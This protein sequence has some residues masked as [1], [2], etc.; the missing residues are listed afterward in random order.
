MRRGT[1]WLAAM[2]ILTFG[3]AACFGDVNS[4]TDTD[5]PFV[6]IIF[7]R[8]DSTVAGLVT[9]SATVQDAF[10]VDKVTFTIDGN[11][12]FEDRLPPFQANWNTTSV[13]NGA[14]SIRVEATDPS[15]NKGFQN[16]G[17][18]VDNRRN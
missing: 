4:Q 2:A 1:G 5:S 11:L 15:G 14:H 9:I 18:L 8:A 6:D 10:G 13:G 16:I 7:P 3:S 17:V 12:L